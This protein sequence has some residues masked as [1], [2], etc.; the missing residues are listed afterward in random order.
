MKEKLIYFDGSNKT[1]KTDSP[2][3]LFGEPSQPEEGICNEIEMINQSSLPTLVITL[4]V[5]NV[6]EEHMEGS[7][8]TANSSEREAG[9]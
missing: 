8:A 1:S 3:T 2:S 9:H 4:K 5:Q 6:E 7:P